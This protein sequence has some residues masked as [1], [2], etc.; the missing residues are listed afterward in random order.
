MNNCKW[1][2]KDE[3][4]GLCRNM[5]IDES[6]EQIKSWNKYGESKVPYTVVILGIVFLCA[7]CAMIFANIPPTI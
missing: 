7:I 6:V 5:E 2:T 4:C 1:C 3:V